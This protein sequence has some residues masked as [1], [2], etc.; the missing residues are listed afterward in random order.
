[1]KLKIWKIKQ[2]VKMLLLIDKKK[3]KNRL[4]INT[5]LKDKIT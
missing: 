5:I 3:Y 2:N 1:M 4:T